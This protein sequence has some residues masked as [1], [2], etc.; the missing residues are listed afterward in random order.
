MARPDAQVERHLTAFADDLRRVLGDELVGVALY[1]SA[2]GEDWVAGV[3]DLNTVVVVPRVTPDVLE[4]LVPVVARARPHGF[5][6]PAVMDHEYLARARDTFPIE[7]D[8]IRRQHRVL[9][10]GDVFRDV[11]VEP[12]AVRRQC[13]REAREKL[14]RL[15]ALFL[16]AAGDAGALERLMVASVKS[17][18]IL[19]RHLLRLRRQ[20][21]PQAYAAVLDAGTALLGP[22]PAM[23]RLLARR[24]GGGA[25]PPAE[26]H[27]TFAAYLGEVERIVA[28]VDALDA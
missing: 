8:D 21:A 3:S 2:A 14:L 26:V 1:G 15:R 6:L 20:D 16:E 28:A 9:A 24:R 18:L 22:L 17:F 7:L 12:A 19:L 13:E 27:A 25:L 23:H 4:R 11:A 5:A 10:G